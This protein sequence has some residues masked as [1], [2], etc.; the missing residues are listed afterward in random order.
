[1]SQLY[2]TKVTSIG[3]RAGTVHSEDGLLDLKLALPKAMGGQGD[4]PNPEQLFA[5][6][7]S[8]CFASALIHSTRRQEA[9]IQDNDVTIVT[10]VGLGPNDSGGFAL[11]V[12]MDITIAGLDQDSAEEAV[13]TAHAICP[14]SN[15]I[16]GNIDVQFT[17]TGIP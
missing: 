17:V 2:S 5:A 11:S 10:E 1:M 15:A 14:Y 13:R 8:A 12:A 16:K 3:G 9:K 4:A 7:Y 6:G